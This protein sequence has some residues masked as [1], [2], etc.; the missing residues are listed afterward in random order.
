MHAQNSEKIR[1]ATEVCEEAPT[2]TRGIA[3]N[4]IANAI[5]QTW[6]VSD[7]MLLNKFC[8]FKLKQEPA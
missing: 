2:E 8:A 4:K 7:K 3:G 6:I 1:A 5:A